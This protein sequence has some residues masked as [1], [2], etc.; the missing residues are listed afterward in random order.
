MRSWRFWFDAADTAP[1]GGLWS[2]RGAGPPGGL[3]VPVTPVCC[4][5]K[6]SRCADRKRERCHILNVMFTSNLFS[7]WSLFGGPWKSVKCTVKVPPVWSW[8]CVQQLLWNFP[9]ETRPSSARTHLELDRRRQEVTTCG[10]RPGHV[11]KTILFPKA[12]QGLERFKV[13]FQELSRFF[14]VLMVLLEFSKTC[15][16][17]CVNVTLKPASLHFSS[18]PRKS[19]KSLCTEH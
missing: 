12:I 11:T 1:P 4:S 6:S 8:R 7:S 10:G 13:Q 15:G 16:H 9:S 14:K 5:C 19:L 3:C 2:W 18:G 17:E